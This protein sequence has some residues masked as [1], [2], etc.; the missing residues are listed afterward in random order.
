V[1]DD[2]HK[3]GKSSHN[4]GSGSNDRGQLSAPAR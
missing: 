2:N 1:N 4:I 3:R